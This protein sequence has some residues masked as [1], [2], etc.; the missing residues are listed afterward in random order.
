MNKI[1]LDKLCEFTST[2]YKNYP[3]VKD[4]D[5]NINEHIEL[6]KQNLSL[7]EKG[8]I[9]KFNYVELNWL[10]P[11]ITENELVLIYP[12]CFN[13]KEYEWYCLLN[14][15]LIV[16]ND[17]YLYKTNVHKK[18]VIETFDKTYKKKINIPD[19]LTGELIE[20]IAKLTNITIIVLTFD[21]NHIYNKKESSDHKYIVLYKNNDEYYPVIN[22]D[23]KH[24]KYSDY[25]IKYL[26]NF[27][28][29]R[30]KNLKQKIKEANEKHKTIEK[31]IENV[32]QEANEAEKLLI[33]KSKSKSNV[34]IAEEQKE[35]E[36]ET[37][38]ESKKEKAKTDKL[39]QFYEE[40][41]TNNDN[42][43]L[44]ISEAVG[45]KDIVT[46]TSKKNDDL[47]KKKT[48]KNSKDIFVVQ[49]DS[50]DVKDVKDVK[51][52]KDVKDVKEVKDVNNNIIY[53]D[54]SVFVA[55]E[56]ITKKD[57]QNIKLILKASLT[58]PELQEIAQ[59]LS[60][61]VVEGS[62]KTG[63]PKRKTKGELFDDIEKYINDF[64]K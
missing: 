45:D 7:N 10:V 46:S 32:I 5:F 9:N 24:Y 62:T 31:E 11:D 48:K 57:I 17:E 54:D 36:K 38:K 51:N 23:N 25:F 52:V 40:V 60:I 2:T 30:N 1:F 8:I 64:E 12:L 50:K 43:A 49:K 41:V 21:I 26:I 33:K 16:L 4:K 15:L 14:A 61:N 28:E 63:K 37:L 18:V 34:K 47:T 20:K 56:K 44:Y 3:V 35:I 29:E 19:K 6:T 58:L 13:T 53:E 39:N 59:K 27:I 55:T 42:Y 22:W